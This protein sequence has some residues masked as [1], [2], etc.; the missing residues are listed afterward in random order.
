MRLI[1]TSGISLIFVI[2]AHTQGSVAVP[3]ITDISPDNSTLHASDPDGSAAGRVNGLAV[4]GNVMYASSEW[5]GL[6][7][8]LDRGQTWAHLDS[9]L[10]VALWR[11]GVDPTN[12][13]RIVTTSFYDGR[14]RSLSGINVSADGGAT[15]SH[16]AS[17]VPPLHFCRI[18]AFQQEL[19]A[20]GI[21]F[22]RENRNNIYVGTSCGLAISRDSGNTWS[23]VDP[24]PN[25]PADG[26]WD[27]N[28]HDDG[29]VDVCGDDGHARSRDRGKTWI[30]PRLLPSGRCSIAVSPYEPDVLFAVVG[31]KLYESDDGGQHWG[32]GLST[33]NYQG[34]IPF[35]TANKRS[36]GDFD[37]W[38]GDVELYRL[39]CKTPTVA[40]P[41]IRRCQIGTW[42]ETYTRNH[43]AHDDVGQ[44]VFE[45]SASVNAC[46]LAFSSDGGVYVNTLSMDPNCQSPIW[47]QPKASPHS[48][49]FFGMDGV[50]NAAGG[51]ED[52]YFGNQDSGAFYSRQAGSGV[53]KWT[54]FDC[55]DSFTRASS[56]ST[57]VYN[58]C[59]YKDKNHP[60]RENQLFLADPGVKN[61]QQLGN[62]P[63]GLIPGWEAHAVEHI[64]GESFLVLTTAGLFRTPNIRAK[65]VRWDRLGAASSPTDA[66]GITVSGAE[67]ALH[68]L[69]LQTG[70]CSGL[71]PSSIYRL[72][73]QANP[74][75]WVK[76]QPPQSASGFGVFAVGGSGTEILAAVFDKDSNQPAIVLSRDGGRV[77]IPLHNVDSLLTANGGFEYINKKGPT[78]FTAFDG[79][80]QPSSLALDPTDPLLMIAA[81][82]DSGVFASSDGGTTWA[83]VKSSGGRLIPRVRQIRFLRGTARIAYLGS[84]GAGIWRLSW[85]EP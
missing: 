9:H 2:S 33:P 6:F 23:Y 1:V 56:A 31:D 8:S 43:G 58:S 57:V 70:D 81:G 64:E 49:W 15:W 30:V 13:N 59:C 48:L 39:A 26:I 53:A 11:V 68:S 28:V 45:P 17:V 47:D 27:V 16:P 72:D 20:F 63:L 34:R 73:E 7:K 84:Q 51:T 38:F 10:P 5:G 77:W 44:L 78:D 3:R 50:S 12:S 40:K 75:R 76:I 19:T 82:V 66:C 46:P 4:S 25:D 71:T 67:H 29:I 42:G 36:G 52:L 37:L 18:P 61:P 62:Y 80:P 54:N 60:V 35:V 83:A 65:P 21:A 24:S 41:T 79:Y 55:C 22:E 85:K 74:A 14:A 69:F 32:V